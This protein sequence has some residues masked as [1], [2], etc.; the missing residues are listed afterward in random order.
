MTKQKAID[1]YNK[2]FQKRLSEIP[3][4]VEKIDVRFNSWKRSAFRHESPH[5]CG[6]TPDIYFQ[7]L[8]KTDGY[9]LLDFANIS[10]II[11]KKTPDQLRMSFKEYR[12]MQDAL[13]DM[14]KVW[15]ELVSP[16][17]EAVKKKIE[18][19]STHGGAYKEKPLTI[20]P[21]L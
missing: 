19:M 12:E 11:E 20:A 7:A 2:E 18:I 13:T 17:R 5:S 14:S 1:V 8:E 3:F 16:I 15:E 10:N 21:T 4:P 6:V 9:S